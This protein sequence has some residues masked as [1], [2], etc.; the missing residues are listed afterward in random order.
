[1]LIGL[2]DRLTGRRT[3]TKVLLVD[4]EEITRYLVRQ[5]L[6]RGRYTLDVASNG[7]EGLQHL[8]DEPPDVVL[9]DVN[10]PEMNG[11][12]FLERAHDDANGAV[13]R[14]A[15][16]P[17]DRLDLRH[18]RS[19]RTF[20]AASRFSDHVQIGFVGRH[21][22]RCDRGRPAS[23]AFG[24]GCNERRPDRRSWWSTMMRADA[25]SRRTSCGRTATTSPPPATGHSAIE[26]C[27][28]DLPDLVLL[29]TRLPDIIGVEVCQTIK[30]RFPGVA[31]L[32]TSAASHQSARSRAGAGRRR[33]RVP[34]RTDRA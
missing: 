2:L 32:Q 13:S 8:R 25:T 22:D 10:M 33:R 14:T 6:P 34:D 23:G 11:Y 4:D 24:A 16:V 20:I 19:G 12:Q 15:N 7:E 29:D 1:M 5:L 27:E 28:T 9:L 26:H 30:A 17:I 31:V 18:S 21:A 3:I